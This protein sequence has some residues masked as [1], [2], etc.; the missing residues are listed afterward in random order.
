MRKDERLALL[1]E[2][3][4]LFMLLDYHIKHRKK[5]GMDDQEFDNYVNAALERL[6]EIKKLLA[7]STDRPWT[8]IL[9]FKTL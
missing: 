7:E 4:I 8:S 6:S 1:E 9:L 5:I 2:Q 3:Q